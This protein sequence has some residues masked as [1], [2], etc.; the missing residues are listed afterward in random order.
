MVD[1]NAEIEVGV[2]GL[3]LARTKVREG[4]MWAVHHITR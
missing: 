2:T 3:S 4:V 1:N